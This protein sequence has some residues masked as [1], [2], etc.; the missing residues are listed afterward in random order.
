[1]TDVARS[2]IYHKWSARTFLLT[3]AAFSL[4]QEQGAPS[5]LIRM[6]R[7]VESGLKTSFELSMKSS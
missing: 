2:R 1:M 3:M 5:T 4:Q 6:G 7:L